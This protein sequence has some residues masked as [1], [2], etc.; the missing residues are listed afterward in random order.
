MNCYQSEGLEVVF[1]HIFIHVLKIRNWWICKKL[2]RRLPRTQIKYQFLICSTALES[3]RHT[4]LS[5][6]REFNASMHSKSEIF[7]SA[8]ACQ[9]NLTFFSVNE[10]I[11]SRWGAKCRRI[12]QFVFNALLLE[13]LIQLQA[14]R[15]L[16][17]DEWK[18]IFF[19]LTCSCFF[20]MNTRGNEWARI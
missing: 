17:D 10:Q 7:F 3:R 13:L 12:L 19:L 1:A 8:A 14:I 20:S 2:R 16:E 9:S 6:N 11:S 4:D 5:S 18:L 15:S